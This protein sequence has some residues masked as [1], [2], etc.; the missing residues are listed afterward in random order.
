M[1]SIPEKT[2]EHWAS[3]YL[4]SRFPNGAMWWP[5]SGEDVL[6]ALPRLAASGPGKTLALELKTTEAT[7]T[8]HALWID[9]RQLD[10]YLNPP[11]GPPLPVY[12]VFPV[13]HWTGPL[14]SWSGTAPA[15][16]ATMTAAPP[17]W[18]RRRVGWPWFGDW[19]YV[20][21]AQSLSEALPTTWT[22]SSKAKAKLFTLNASRAVGMKPDWTTLFTRTPTAAPMD[23]TSFWKVVTRCGPHDGVRWRTIAGEGDQPDRVLVLSSNEEREWQFDQL[24]G[25]LRRELEPLA[26]D[27]GGTERVVLHVPESALI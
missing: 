10:R 16:P 11:S 14:T 23:W 7:R 9:T 17:E 25:R 4:S 5:T 3:I 27:E 12:Y 19:L 6:A 21:S 24:P 26:A 20:M 18:W 13:P 1:R 2:L 15:A 8:D 22:A